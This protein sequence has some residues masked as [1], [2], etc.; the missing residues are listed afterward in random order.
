VRPMG[1]CI[2]IC[3]PFLLADRPGIAPALS[4]EDA[5]RG[6]LKNQR[7]VRF[8][9]PED[10]CFPENAPP[11]TG[12][13]K[14]RAPIFRT[15]LKDWNTYP[16]HG[17]GLADLAPAGKAPFVRKAGALSTLDGMDAAGVAVEHDALVVFLLDEGEAL[18]VG[19]EAGE[20][21]EEIRFAQFQE[22]GDARDLVVLDPDV[23]GPLAAGGAAL[24][25]IMNAGFEVDVVVA[26]AAVVF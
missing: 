20:A 23:T 15:P 21:V 14:I 25:D 5:L 22:R 1:H 3:L 16:R 13:L 10:P 24:A 12:G 7:F 11:T 9:V 18:A 4:L 26:G 17:D 2:V 19:A 8:V 6:F